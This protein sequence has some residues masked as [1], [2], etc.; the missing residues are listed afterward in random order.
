MTHQIR[1]VVTGHD[2]KGRAVIISDG[3]AP[4]YTPTSSNRIDVGKHLTHSQDAG[5]YRCNLHP[6]GRA[7]GIV[8]LAHWRWSFGLANDAEPALSIQQ[9]RSATRLRIF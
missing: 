2:E 5:Q 8:V 4:S 6:R 9:H 3:P 1:R 7:A